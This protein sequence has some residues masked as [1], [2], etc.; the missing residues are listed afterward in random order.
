VDRQDGKNWQ[1]KILVKFSI[2]SVDEE[3]L[4]AATGSQ[5]RPAAVRRLESL[6]RGSAATM[7]EG[8]EAGTDSRTTR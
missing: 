7:M 1:E 5:Q 4:A 2:R 6:E 3:K 8:K